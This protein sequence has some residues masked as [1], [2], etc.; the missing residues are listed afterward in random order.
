[1]LGLSS[2]GLV[3]HVEDGDCNIPKFH[4]SEVQCSALLRPA[5]N[6]RLQRGL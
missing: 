2:I 5:L 4:P 3:G 6:A 1:L